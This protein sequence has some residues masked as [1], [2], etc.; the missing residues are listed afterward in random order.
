MERILFLPGDGQG[1]SAVS[2]AARIVA[3]A[4]DSVEAVAGDIGSAAYERYGEFLPY[5]TLDLVGNTP[6]VVC[7]PTFDTRDG[8]N[9]LESMMTQMDLYGRRRRF[10]ALADGM[11][12]PG[13]DVTVWGTSASGRSGI[14]ETRDVDG[15]TISKYISTASYARVMGAAMTDMELSGKT[16]AAC[17]ARE[18]MFPESSASI[19]EAFDAMFGREG[20]ACSHSSVVDWVPDFLR[21]PSS[22]E[23]VVASDLYAILAEKLIGY[24]AGGEALSPVKHVGDGRTLILPCGDSPAGGP[25]CPVASVVTASEALAD[26]GHRDEADR[27]MEALGAAL[28]ERRP[29][30]AGGDLGTEA[31]ADLVISRLRGRELLSTPSAYAE[32]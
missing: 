10:R 16:R 11:G 19:Y 23:M 24:I 18:D 6:V 2:A 21:D 4:D 12:A 31:F 13:A 14:S 7:G 27:V 29:V 3:A 17:I 28:G 22:Y 1:P 32:A 8:R 20:V 9:P 30:D 25:E 5:E 26:I 15:I